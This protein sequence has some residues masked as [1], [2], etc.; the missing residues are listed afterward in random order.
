MKKTLLLLS[1]F[2]VTCTL[3]FSQSGNTQISTQKIQTKY[4]NNPKYRVKHFYKNYRL[5]TQKKKES[6]KN[7]L[8]G[9]LKD[10]SLIL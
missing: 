2:F 1:L 10:T 9:I 6:N 3:S 5:V 8:H 4:H 7:Q